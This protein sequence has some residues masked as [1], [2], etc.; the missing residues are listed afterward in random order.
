MKNY[1]VSD[2]INKVQS[3]DTFIHIPNNYWLI[4]IRSN[5]DQFNKFDDMFYL[6]YQDF[7][8]R[9]YKGTTNPGATALKNFETYNKLGAAVLKSNVIVYDS[10][11]RG[12]HRGKVLAYRQGKSF[13]YYRDNNKNDR[14]EEIGEEYNDIIYANIHPSS[15]LEGQDITTE[16][17]NGWSLACQV[18]ANTT[19]YY[20]FMEKTQDQQFLTYCLLKEF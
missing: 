7:I 18:F 6:M 5:E 12:L 16:Y 3:L 19:E 11:Y 9:T 20:D 13:P 1:L 8:I 2:I 10:H 15:Y 14:S 4:G 17:I